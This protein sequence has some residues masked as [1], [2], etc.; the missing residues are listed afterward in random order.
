MISVP[1]VVG[2]DVGSRSSRTLISLEPPLLEEIIF[3]AFME[4]AATTGLTAASGR[5]YSQT[6]VQQ[7]LEGKWGVRP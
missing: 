7:I 2:L 6:T 5:A 1:M 4:G 3:A